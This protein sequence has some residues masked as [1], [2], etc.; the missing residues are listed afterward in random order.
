M[1]VPPTAVLL[2]KVLEV[3]VTCASTGREHIVAAK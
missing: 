1:H 2:L 3:I